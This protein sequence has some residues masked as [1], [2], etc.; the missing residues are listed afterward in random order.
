[1]AVLVHVEVGGQ[2]HLLGPLPDRDA[3]LG[4][5]VPVVEAVR[6]QHRARHVLHAGQHLAVEPEVAEVAGVAVHVLRV[7]DGA[8]DAIVAGLPHLGAAG[9]DDLVKDVHV[10]ADVA[11]GVPH[12]AGLAVV[13]VVRRVGGHGDDDLQP[14]D[15]R[16]GGR[17]AERAVVAG[18]G[19]A[20]AAGTPVGGD[21][22]AAVAL[23]EALGPAAE[24]VHDGGGAVVLV[25]AADGGAAVRK[26]RAGRGRV[27]HREAA[28]HPV[29]DVAA[30]QLRPVDLDGRL[31]DELAV[32]GGLAQLVAGVPHGRVVLR[33]AAAGEVG[34]A[35]EDGGDFE[36]VVGLF[37]TRDGD[38]DAVRA[39]VLVGVEL[40]LHEEVVADPVLLVLEGRDD[41]GPAV[42]DAV[43]QFVAG[44][45]G[46]GVEFL[47][48]FEV[49][50]A[51]FA[52]GLRSEVRAVVLGL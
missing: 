14:L 43:G 41:G 29:L 16:H 1:M 10:L 25:L 44:G 2:A 11:A 15:A 26:P 12:E 39:A 23:G 21:G 13:A 42:L 5:H 28:G 38:V 37:R 6:H 35:V 47:E 34:A 19:H 22:L 9:V 52:G 50:A 40:G 49:A 24:P 45:V 20:D 31:R 32:G 18:A 7:Q 33:L 17:E 27:N 51:Q 3:V 36:A 48:G 46:R 4:H 8:E 30:R